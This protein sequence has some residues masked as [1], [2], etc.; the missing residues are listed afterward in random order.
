MYLLYFRFIFVIL[1]VTVVSSSL[2]L[3]WFLL[4]PPLS[5]RSDSHRSTTNTII[6]TTAQSKKT[7]L[8]LKSTTTATM[9]TATSTTT[10]DD[11]DVDADE[12]HPLQMQEHHIDDD[13]TK[14]LQDAYAYHH[15]ASMAVD[16][17]LAHLVYRKASLSTRTS[18]TD[19]MGVIKTNESQQQQQL[20]LTIQRSVRDIDENRR[21]KYLYT[22]PFTVMMK[23]TRQGL[24]CTTTATTAITASESSSSPPPPPPPSF[25]IPP[26]EIM[27]NV[28]LRLPSPSGKYIAIFRTDDKKDTTTA[29]TVTPIVLE[30]WDDYGMSLRRRIELN[31]LLPHERRRRHGTVA[32][33]PNG[34]F[35]IPSWNVAETCLVYVAEQT[36]P[37]TKSYF[38][39]PPPSLNPTK[40]SLMKH[41]HN[42]N[43]ND[44]G[45][46]TTRTFGQQHVLGVGKI[47]HYGEKYSQH[48][49]YHSI[50][51]V[52]I[53]TG[54]VGIVSNVPISTTTGSTPPIT[55]G[56]VQFCPPWYSKTHSSSNSSS[57]ETSKD[58]IVEE[59]IV[60][61][62]WGNPPEAINN[63]ATN[64]YTKRLG[65]IYCQQRPCQLY[66][67]K[68]THLL[69]QLSMTDD[70]EYHDGVEITKN[71][72]ATTSL[73]MI[74]D[75]PFQVL[76]NDMKLSH[77]P[78][79]YLPVENDF[80]AD[81]MNLVF[82]T[83]RHG[84]DTHSGCFAIGKINVS[85]IFDL[86]H[87][88]KT[89]TNPSL[90]TI[91]ADE[92]WAPT[93]ENTNRSG[94]D[95]AP[96]LN[97]TVAGLKFPGFFLQ[98]LPQSCFI[99]SEYIL[100]TTQWGSCQKVVR[101]S[102]FSGTIHLISF[103]NENQYSS[104]ELLFCNHVG[105]IVSSKSPNK[106]ATVRFIPVDQ[107]LTPGHPADQEQSII[108]STEIGTFSPIASSKIAL[109][110]QLRKKELPM[111]SRTFG[112]DIRV[113]PVTTNVDGASCQHQ[114]ESILLLPT[115]KITIDQQSIDVM[116]SSSP[117]A[118][119]PLIVIP[120]G[121]PHSASITNFVI[122]YAYL[123]G[124]GRYAI[125][126][127][128]YR[129]ST[130]YGQASIRSLPTN[131]GTQDVE[132]VITAT[133]DVCQNGLVDAN[134]I[135]IC[136]G[137]HGGFLTAHLTGQYPN[138]FKAAVMR[139]PVVNL[140][141]MVTSTDIPD[142]CYVEACGTY[143]FDTY[144]P[145]TMEEL[146]TFYKVS[147]IQYIQNVQT[148][149]LIALGLKDLRVPP[150]QGMEWY[151]S[152]RGR[153][154]PP[155]PPTKL[156]LYENDDHAIDGV[157]SE[158]DHWIHIKQWFDQYLR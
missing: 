45:T 42:N 51:C 109:T 64:T 1:R 95:I 143:N 12:S 97:G 111:L 68:V 56:Q 149:T 142:W 24:S 126:L 135:G 44:D 6:T 58:A 14:S 50:F 7:T 153:S 54:H 99:S 125:L 156:L 69:H 25:Q 55:L 124:Y 93:I 117:E 115:T 139:N 18:C 67:S 61:T 103:P 146:Q 19:E 102:I 96:I 49:L 37:N 31:P 86:Y 104:D 40:P 59:S 145:P 134:R 113:L 130:G 132:D 30:I 116:T 29:T 106:P 38:D 114:I 15:Y 136:G 110:S 78:R 112:F 92:V 48:I 155:S 148:P 21:R 72:I 81:S 23:T 34:A 91:V 83:S 123:C 66:H 131:I 118:L 4:Q 9:M 76:T 65:F 121:G 85:Q 70:N 105:A 138:M 28:L 119:P 43:D 47:E 79:F 94:I 140:P 144:R 90:T 147:P 100:V 57:S 8:S 158:A 133:N 73:K 62:G 22:I 10:N 46:T 26:Q 141:S 71:D 32:S 84:F 74:Q 82:L 36:L 129:G 77:S 80:V 2:L 39:T 35:G 17:S 63:S 60:Y 11:N 87:C 150:S 108:V 154:L 98:Q 157:A 33:D 52:D 16:L 151:Y 120:H 53:H 128:N 3:Q 5:V 89:V 101:V 13:D 20:V 137:S 88:N 127:V 27:T 122:S 152:L 41:H 75:P 107:L